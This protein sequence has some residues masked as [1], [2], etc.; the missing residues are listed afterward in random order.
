MLGE[1]VP[2]ARTTDPDAYA[3]FLQSRH[4]LNRY[5]KDAYA[6]AESLLS[7]SIAIDP[8]FAPA[9]LGLG[10]VYGTQEDFGRPL[11]EGRTLAEAAFRKKT[12]AC[13]DRCIVWI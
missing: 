1:A 5:T 2:Q 7:E 4:V 12:Q 11:D 9:W 6:Q 3:L 8:G 13:I 10:Q